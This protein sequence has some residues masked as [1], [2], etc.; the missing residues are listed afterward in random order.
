MK[1]FKDLGELSLK[2]KIIEG[3]LKLR[4]SFLKEKPI[5]VS[6]IRKYNMKIVCGKPLESVKIKAMNLTGYEAY[7]YEPEILIN[8]EWII[9]YLHGGGY[10]SGSLEVY[11]GFISRFANGLKLKG[12]AF[13][14]PLAPEKPYPEAVNTTVEFYEKIIA[15]GH[16]P[17]KIIMAGDSAGGGLCLAVGLEL[18]KKNILP[19]MFV[20]FS[21]WVDLTLSGESVYT[22]TEKDLTLTRPLLKHASALYAGTYPRKEPGI[23]PMFGNFKGFPPVYLLAAKDELLYSECEIL[24]DSLQKSGVDVYFSVWEKAQHAFI[25]GMNLFPEGETVLQNVENFIYKH[26]KVKNLDTKK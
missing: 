15:N 19:G 23:S 3:V 4:K 25:V 8:D 18:H 22:N 26:M 21:P 1:E 14:Y 10:V 7:F 16:D 20:L 24:Y 17:K 2:T 5:K 13:G 6:K 12:Y 11:N 9:F